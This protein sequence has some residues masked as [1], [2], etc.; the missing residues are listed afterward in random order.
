[1]PCIALHTQPLIHSCM[2]PPITHPHTP[3]FH[4]PVYPS[5]TAAASLTCVASHQKCTAIDLI[6]SSSPSSE[7]FSFAALLFFFFFLTNSPGLQSCS[8]ALQ[9]LFG[10]LKHQTL[11]EIFHGTSRFRGPSK[12]YACRRMNY[13]WME[14]NK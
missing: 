9:P 2:N 10:L 7:P 5:S 12:A 11:A 13:V 3:F 14:R 8:P 6:P 1:M 4:L